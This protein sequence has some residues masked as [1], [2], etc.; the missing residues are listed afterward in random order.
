MGEEKALLKC[1][2]ASGKTQANA[3]VSVLE[4]QAGSWDLWVTGP[5]AIRSGRVRAT[6]RVR[7][8]RRYFTRRLTPLIGSNEVGGLAL[9]VPG[10]GADTV[11]VEVFH[12]TGG[13]AFDV[14]ARPRLCCE[15]RLEPLP[16]LVDF[17]AAALPQ[18]LLVA[19][20]LLEGVAV[21]NLNA[22]PAYL[23][24]WDRSAAPGAD[25][26]DFAIPCEADGAIHEDVNY[27]VTTALWLGWSLDPNTFTATPSGAAGTLWV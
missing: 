10:F 17:A 14:L 24:G 9:S 1:G 6:A 23:L 11:E 4:L 13:L 2:Y 16:L 25:A 3:H 8:S 20:E 21:G 15:Q 19:G 7:S 5:A 12:P 18:S 26:P 27:R 22:T